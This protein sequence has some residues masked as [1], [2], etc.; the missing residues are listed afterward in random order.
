[1]LIAVN[2]FRQLPLY[3]PQQLTQYIDDGRRVRDGSHAPDRI[4]AL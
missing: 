2:P 4:D 3:G 1:M